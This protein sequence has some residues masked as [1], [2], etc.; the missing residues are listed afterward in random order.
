L[1]QSTKSS[2]NSGIVDWRGH[3]TTNASHEHVAALGTDQHIVAIATYQHR[4]GTCTVTHLEQDVVLG[5]RH[6]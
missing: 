6:G 3:G 1:R 4:I 5:R 2:S